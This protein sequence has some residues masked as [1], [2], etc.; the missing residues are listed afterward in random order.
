[1]QC[2]HEK[3]PSSCGLL[4]QVS[5]QMSPVGF[6]IIL[7]SRDWKKVIVILVQVLVTLDDTYAHTYITNAVNINPNLFLALSAVGCVR[8]RCCMFPFVFLINSPSA[9]STPT[10]SYTFSAAFLVIIALLVC[11]CRHIIKLRSRHRQSHTGV[12]FYSQ[13][14]QE[15]HYLRCLGDTQRSIRGRNGTDMI[16][17]QWING[18]FTLRHLMKAFPDWQLVARCQKNRG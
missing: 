9:S 1:M 12:S 18:W 4:F 3:K 15:R 7:Y 11:H 14:K 17:K 6:W 10:L 8:T 13:W 2:D 5:T 16:E